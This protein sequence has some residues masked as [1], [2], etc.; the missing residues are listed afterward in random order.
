MFKGI[1]E[2]LKMKILTKLRK[3]EKEILELEGRKREEAMKVY[4]KLLFSLRDEPIY[5]VRY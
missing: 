2:E 3:L 4:R 5:F 1:S